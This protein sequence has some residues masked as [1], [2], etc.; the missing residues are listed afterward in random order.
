MTVLIHHGHANSVIPLMFRYV[1]ELLIGAVIPKVRD[2]G[3][4][5]PVKVTD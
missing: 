2:L 1:C 5:S 4:N 3:E